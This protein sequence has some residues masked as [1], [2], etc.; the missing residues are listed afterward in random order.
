MGKTFA[1]QGIPEGEYDISHGY[2][3]PCARVLFAQ[4]KFYESPAGGEYVIVRDENA[5]LISSDLEVLWSGPLSKL[6]GLSEDD[7]IPIGEV[8]AEPLRFAWS[9]TKDVSYNRG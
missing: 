4:V 6:S 7:R 9:V 3:P 2:C 8:P 5:W 1:P